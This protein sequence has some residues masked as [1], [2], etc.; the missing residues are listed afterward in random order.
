MEQL[1][2]TL[3][4]QVKQLEDNCKVNKFMKDQT[5]KKMKVLDSLTH[6]NSKTLKVLLKQSRNNRNNRSIDCK[7]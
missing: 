7:Y 4:N 6:Q 1:H 5:K 2:K 3:S